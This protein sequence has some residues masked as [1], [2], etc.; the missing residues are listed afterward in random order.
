VIAR[1]VMQF[2]FRLKKEE[3]STVK[4]K[5]LCLALLIPFAMGIQNAS[6]APTSAVQQ[7]AEILLTLDRAPTQQQV[8]Q[9]KELDSS[10]ML[11]ANEHRLT[12]VMMNING[13]IRAED[14]QMLWDV[15]RTVS[16]AEGERELAKIINEF[17]TKINNGERRRLERLLPPKPKPVAAKKE[18]K[19]GDAGKK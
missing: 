18:A 12:K 9:L 7:M 13:T 15:F 8:E 10:D 17:D 4:L 6:A 5:A 1:K 2:V 19:K 11:T 3:E 16:A 14:K